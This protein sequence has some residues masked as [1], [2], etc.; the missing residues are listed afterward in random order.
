MKKNKKDKG[1]KQRVRV[2]EATLE[3]RYCH[4]KKCRKLFTPRHETN[5]H[6]SDLCAAK[7]LRKR[8]K[9]RGFVL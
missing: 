3:P 1:K 9:K 7:C 8:E 4:R 2:K 5:Y 6:C